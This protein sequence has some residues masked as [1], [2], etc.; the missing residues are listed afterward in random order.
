[1]VIKKT[2]EILK[3]IPN[4]LNL[5]GPVISSQEV[6]GAGKSVR[7]ILDV[8][9]GRISHFTKK[10]IYKKIELKKLDYK[11]VDMPS[12]LLPVSFNERT[13]DIILNLHF[14]GTDDVSRISYKDLYGLLVYGYCFKELATFKFKIS[15]DYAPIYAQ[16][17][18]N[19]MMKLFGKDYGLIGTFSAEIS[20]LKFITLCYVSSSFFGVPQG[21]SLYD[22]S[23]GLSKYSYKE[24]LEEFNPSRFDFTSFRQYIHSLDESKCMPGIDIYKFSL[25]AIRQFGFSFLPAFEDIGRFQSLFTVSDLFGTRLA[26]GFIRKFNEPSFRSIMT[27]S[28]TIFRKIK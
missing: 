18:V 3:D 6:K 23:S 20:K 25:K 21:K 19:I 9:S 7:S 26:P 12:Y 13:S 15:K 5:S 1:M 10:F 24:Y 4:V 2:L 22:Y 27:I 14:F 17:I 8:S 16:F 28:E 11:V